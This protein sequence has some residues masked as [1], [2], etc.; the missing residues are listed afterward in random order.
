MVSSPTQT[1]QETG[2]LILPLFFPPF[3]FSFFSPCIT[4]LLPSAF[5]GFQ[6]F[7]VSWNPRLFGIP[8]YS[9]R[10]ASPGPLVF[11]SSPPDFPCV[12][13]YADF[14]PV[15]LFSTEQIKEFCTPLF[16]VHFSPVVFSRIA[17]ALHF[18]VFGVDKTFFPRSRSPPLS[19]SSHF[20][21]FVFFRLRVFFSRSVEIALQGFPLSLFP[22]PFFPFYLSP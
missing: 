1:S 10:G 17:H 7:L 20:G 4:F 6:A 5:V 2:S 8:A 15:L 12:I 3:R 22:T 16:S 18:T 14:R 19:F 21:S 13:A 11:I 9:N